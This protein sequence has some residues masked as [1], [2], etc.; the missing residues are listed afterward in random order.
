[1]RAILFASPMVAMLLGI[2]AWRSGALAGIAPGALKSSVAPP[3]AR[4]SVPSEFG[5]FVQRI[6]SAPQ[7]DLFDLPAERREALRESLRPDPAVDV[8]LSTLLH[9]V[10]V[11]GGDLTITI[12]DDERAVRCLDVLLDV[13]SA[14]RLY[15]HGHSLVRTR[16]GVRVP[17]I[18]ESLLS[19]PQGHSQSHHG[20]VLATLAR[21]GVAL[22]H[23]LDVGDGRPATV[24]DMLADL[25]A[26]FQLE[27]EIYWDAVALALYVSPETTWTNRFGRRFSFDDLAE[28]LLARDLSD[29]PCAGTHAL[30]SLSV[31]QRVDQESP[32]LSAACRQRLLAFLRS[33][34]DRA[35]RSQQA[36]GL[37]TPLWHA[38]D[39]TAL[40]R[41]KWGSDLSRLDTVLATGHLL[42]WLLLCPLEWREPTR[43]MLTRAAVALAELLGERAK[44]PGWVRYNYCPATHAVSVVLTLSRAAPVVSSADRA[45]DPGA[46]K[47]GAT[48]PGS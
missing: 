4:A 11:F 24:A 31:L 38:E 10:Q 35:A 20:Q 44:H 37:W 48:T 9:A 41:V 28:E 30:I 15:A 5:E 39:P 26:N 12:P 7:R 34:F 6:Y 18:N 8:S 22:S 45:I 2:V 32:V 29:S 16:Y 3:F 23:S 19:T 17:E 47:E 43:E 21:L 25:V 1:M 27:G 14:N 33:K 40:R 42:E 13:Q 36:D 46:R